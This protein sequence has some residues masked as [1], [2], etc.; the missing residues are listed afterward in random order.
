[1]AVSS[2]KL[3]DDLKGRV[4][5]LAD[6]RRRTPHWIM[7]E[8]IAEYVEREEKRESFKREALEAWDD[9][10]R[11]GLH[12]TGEEVDEWLAKLEAGEDAEMP[13]CHT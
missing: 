10:Q 7:R 4:K 2:V 3:D 5:H 1:M 12:L 9:Y 8:A 6:A 11:T 13:A